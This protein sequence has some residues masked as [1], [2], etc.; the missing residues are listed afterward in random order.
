MASQKPSSKPAGRPLSTPAELT[1]SASR[2][3]DRKSVRIDEVG[4]GVF[5]Y[6]AAPDEVRPRMLKERKAL[7]GAPIDHRDAF[8][9]SLIDGRITVATLVDVAGMPEPELRTIL[10]RLARLGIIA[11]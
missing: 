8:V 9:L 2:R 5:E 1:K 4:D 6:S 3:A 10:A 7:A 11:L